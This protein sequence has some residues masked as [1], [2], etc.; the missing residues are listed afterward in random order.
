VGCCW[1]D[2]IMR[3]FLSVEAK[4]TGKSWFPI[5]TTLLLLHAKEIQFFKNF[6]H[7]LLFFLI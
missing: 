3:I 7:G 6:E 1:P 2:R 4:P 5:V